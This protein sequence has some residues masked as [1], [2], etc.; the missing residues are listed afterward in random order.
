MLEGLDSALEGATRGGGG[1]V[2]LSDV[3]GALAHCGIG[4]TPAELRMVMAALDDCT[5]DAVCGCGPGWERWQG[6][7]APS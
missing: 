5:G 7:R 2:E 6:A 4:L 1:R 3:P